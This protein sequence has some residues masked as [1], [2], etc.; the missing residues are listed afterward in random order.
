MTDYVSDFIKAMSDNGIVC[1]DQIITDGKV[2]RFH[3]GGN[4]RDRKSGWYIYFD[5][6]DNP[7]AAYGTW[8][9][10]Y[11]YTWSS[12]GSR[13]FTKAERADFRKQ[14]EADQKRRAEEIQRQRDRAAELANK[15]WDSAQPATEE[16]RYLANK[17]IK[18]HGLRVTTWR[19]WIG[20]R[21][22]IVIENALLVPMKDGGKIRSLQA[23]F[24]DKNNPLGRSKDFLPGAQK[25]GCSYGFGVPKGTKPP[26]IAICEGMATA[27]SVHE[28]T[29]L[30]VVVAF[31]CGNLM[32]VGQRVR[33]AYPDAK[34]IFCADD[35]Y[36][37]D[38]N[39]GV[40]KAQVAAAA[41]MG[42]VAVPDFT[43][44][45]RK[46][47]DSDFNDLHARGGADAV[48]TQIIAAL[49]SN[50][51]SANDNIGASKSASCTENAEPILLERSDDRGTADGGAGIYV[52]RDQNTGPLARR[53]SRQ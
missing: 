27:A 10:D 46:P 17:G 9:G 3:S 15:I 34:I 21:E 22:E 43:D 39:P 49:N 50:P 23:I 12:R 8:R 48:G 36:R 18:S 7:G 14:V 52:Q 44:L 13:Q 47:D 24:P 20:P 40:T 6:D 41:T 37:A 25:S 2:H 11:R 31:D 29:G 30:P 51:S 32:D 16:H 33:K 38:G 35:D 28:C 42:L 45:D 5:H 4:K 26:V 53:L 19:R 1:H